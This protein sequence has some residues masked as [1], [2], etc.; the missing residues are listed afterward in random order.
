MTG[1]LQEE[2]WEH[3]GLTVLSTNADRS[4]IL[5]SSTDDMQEFRERLDAYSRG[6]PRGQKYPSYNAF[7][8]N[9]DTIGPVEPRDRIGARFQE[10]G[11]T[12]LE[13]FA[14]D[15]SY[16]VD[17]ELWDLGRRDLRQRKLDQIAAYVEARGGEVVD[18]YVGPSITMLRV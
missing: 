15:A 16:L 11:Y 5:F 17:I 6:T 4:L 7:I 13:D 14:E 9:I 3:L 18:Q 12:T 2:D 8:G 1:N 10:E